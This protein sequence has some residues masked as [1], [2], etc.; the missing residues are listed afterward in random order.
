[1]FAR[2]TAWFEG[3]HLTFTPVGEEPLDFGG[4]A[5]RKAGAEQANILRVIGANS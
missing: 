4:E 2:L 3:D 5:Q 1:M